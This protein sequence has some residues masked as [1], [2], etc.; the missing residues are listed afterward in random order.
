MTGFFV[1]PQEIRIGYASLF[2]LKEMIE[3]QLL[4]SIYLED[5]EVHL[6]PL[7]AWLRGRKFV[8]IDKQDAQY[9]MTPKG[10]RYVDFFMQRYADFIA[11]Y[12]IYGG[13]DLKNQDFAVR[14]LADFRDPHAWQRFLNEERWIDLRVAVAEYIGF[15]AVE[16]MFLSFMYAGRFGRGPSGWSRDRLLGSVWEEIQAACNSA[17]RLSSL[18]EGPE[19]PP[20]M[21]IQK[22]MDEGEQMMKGLS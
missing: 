8:S 17:V 11:R 4:F 2:L 16:V 22:I 6:E 13:V 18:G 15:D 1:I 9:V 3:N 5:D 20:E 12:D 19:L 10:E 21:V 14:Y 7:F